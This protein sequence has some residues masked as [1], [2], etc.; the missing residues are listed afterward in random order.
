MT[1]V[2]GLELAVSPAPETT[3]PLLRCSASRRAALLL[4]SGGMLS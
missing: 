3:A 2:R 1:T 4:P